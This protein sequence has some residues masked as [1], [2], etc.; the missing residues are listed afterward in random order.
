M[1]Q[2]C[3]L[4]VRLRGE[5]AGSRRLGMMIVTVLKD[6]NVAPMLVE[7][8]SRVGVD[9]QRSKRGQTVPTSY[10]RVP[11]RIGDHRWPEQ[12]AGELLRK[13]QARRGRTPGGRSCARGD[14]TCE[15]G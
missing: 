12:R 9:G 10:R 11:P 2:V 7:G 3:G 13:T 15:T 4:G 6:E 1:H 14:G 8:R 5:A